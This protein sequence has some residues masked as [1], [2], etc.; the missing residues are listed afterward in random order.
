MNVF[1]ITL[2][3][4]FALVRKDGF[5]DNP[6]WWTRVL[7]PFA[8]AWQRNIECDRT[9]TVLAFSAVYACITRIANDIATMP[10]NLV[11]RDS[12]GIWNVVEENSPFWP[13]LRKPNGYQNRI[14]FFVTWLLSKLIN[15]NTYALKE[16]DER[17]IVIALYILDPR[18]VQTRWLTNGDVFYVLS[19]D[20]LAN[21]PAGV[22]VPASEI[23][24]DLMNPLFHPLCG[25]SPLYASGLAASQGR[26]MQQNNALMSEN[27]N[28]P[29]GIVT[30]P[31]DISD[32]QGDKWTRE[33][34]ERFGGANRGNV[35]FLGGGLKYEKISFTAE[36]QQMVEFLNWTAADVARAYGM[37]LYK[38]GAGPV[39]PVGN[40]DM[41]QTQYLNDTLR[42]L[43]E[44]IEIGMD[45]G[46]GLGPTVPRN[47]DLGT[48][49]D[50]DALW[51][52]D[53]VTQIDFLSKAVG[54][55]IMSPDEA[56]LRR[57]LPP[58]EGGKTPY[59][60]QQNY[61][62]AALAKRDAQADPFGT[63]PAPAPVPPPAEPAEEEDEAAEAEAMKAFAAEAQ[64]AI[65]TITKGFADV[66]R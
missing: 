1:G 21:I 12:N 52:M 11:K 4:P 48:E 20:E 39:P 28:V 24:H 36:E 44:A 49:F 65:D 34:R 16:R 63:A 38:I 42:P 10:L 27:A 55:A 31:G 60:Q 46:L 22:T 54:S 15:G 66:R 2:R 56:R 13:V 62:L 51:R 59:L 45:E 29:S 57:N 14:Q 47:A 17:G 3:S 18:K 32:E 41:L 58:V 23:I 26:R 50:L 5:V 40:T 25:V 64:R 43:I 6:R 37:P 9:E 8:G 30:T 33:W 35:A 7:E 61:S 19:N 53:S